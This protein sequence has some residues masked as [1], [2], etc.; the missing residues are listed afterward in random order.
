VDGRHDFEERIQTSNLPPNRGRQSCFAS[1][2]L[3]VTD[4]KHVSLFQV[5]PP[6]LAP[7]LPALSLSFLRSPSRT[8]FTWFST[9]TFCAEPL[10]SSGRYGGE[11]MTASCAI[12][13]TLCQRMGMLLQQISLAQMSIIFEELAVYC[14]SCMYANSHSLQRIVDRLRFFAY[15]LAPIR[16]LVFELCDARGLAVFQ[17]LGVHGWKGRGLLSC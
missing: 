13:S 1:S 11:M 14:K 6:F 4:S 7:A 10:Q 8:F 16:C 15:A 5:Q 3:C 9:C 17:T 12:I 2:R